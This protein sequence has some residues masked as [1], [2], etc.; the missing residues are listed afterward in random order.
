MKTLGFVLLAAALASAT[1]LAAAET[2]ADVIKAFGLRESAK[3]MREVQGWTKPM[4]IAVIVDSAERL[5]WIQQE[6]KGVT[7]VPIRVPKDAAAAIADADAYV[8]VCTLP[9]ISSAKKLR[10]I[11]TQQA[12][13]EDCLAPNVMAGGIVVTNVQRLNGPN[14]AEHAMALLL[15]VSRQLNVALE[16]QLEGKWDPRTMTDA[17]DLDGKTMLIAG[18]GGI[19]TE[20]AKRAHAFGMKIIAT[21]ATSREAPDFVAKVGLASELPQMIGEA[22][23]VVN[24]TPFTP[25]TTKMFDAAMF[26]RMKDG[27]IFINVGR[28][29]SVVT[30]DLVEALDSGKLRGAGIDVTDPDPLPNNHKLWTSPNVIIT[31]HTGATSEIKRER[32][33]LLMRENMRRYVAGD[34]MLSVVDVK[35]GY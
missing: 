1:P 30:D 26:K 6:V 8:G 24:V 27:A 23:V 7:L 34:K 28:G 18:L 10:W 19:G 21:R 20:I 12:G 16:N 29:E 33:W 9:L 2:A 15:A 22:D 3:P 25:E 11:Q 31:P 14:V 13:V 35:K 32:V 17:V 4:K 5:A